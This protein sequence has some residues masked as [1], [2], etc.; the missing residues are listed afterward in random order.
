MLRIL[1]ETAIDVF[2]D[3]GPPSRN[4]FAACL[5][6]PMSPPRDSLVASAAFA[7]GR[8]V[9]D[10]S[11]VLVVGEL[12]VFGEPVAF[13]ANAAEARR[14]DARR[15]EEA[16][17]PGV[18]GLVVGW[19][20]GFVFGVDAVVVEVVAVA[21]DG[22]A[23]VTDLVWCLRSDAA[24]GLVGSVAVEPAEFEALRGVAFEWGDE[25]AWPVGSG[26]LVRERVGEDEEVGGFDLLGTVAAGVV[27]LPWFEIARACYREPADG[28]CG[29]PVGWRAGVAEF[30]AEQV[31]PPFVE[32][33]GVG[34]A[35]VLGVWW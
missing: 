1:V 8:G 30:D 28:R 2:T 23:V 15:C 22:D 3:T 25:A 13:F 12:F 4:A 11:L 14:G 21:E 17:G 9:F 33:V 20:E 35:G 32:P 18:A 10:G 7:L 31:L 29:E 24:K 5:R 27:L 6:A 16:S 26:S 19:V 34:L